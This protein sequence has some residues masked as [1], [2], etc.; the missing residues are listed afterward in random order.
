M[1]GDRLLILF[2]SALFATLLLPHAQAIPA[3]NLPAEI[4]PKPATE[5]TIQANSRVLGILPFADRQDFED[6]ER[7]FLAPLPNGGVVTG[8]DGSAVWDLGRYDFLG[9]D[10]SSASSTPSTVNPSLWRQSQLVYKSGLFKV[11]D[12]IYQVRGIDLSNITFIEGD[13]GLIVL[14]PLVSVEPAKAALELYYQHRP[15]KP[16]IAVL[17]SHSHVDHFGGVKGVTT[18]ADVRAGR[19]Q[20]IAPSGFLEEAVS[21]NVFAGNAMGRRA[22]Y[23]YGQL[24]P[25]GPQGVIGTGLGITTSKGSSSLIPPTRSITRTGEELTIDGLSF[26]FL[27]APDTEA[28]VEMHFYIKELRALCPAENATHTLHNVYTLRGAKIRDPRAWAKALDETIKLFGDKSDVLFAPH[29]WPVWGNERIVDLLEKQRDMYKY[30]NDQTLR[31]A[32]HGYKMNEIAER[33]QVPESLAK[34]WYLRGYYG[35]INHNVK[36]TYVKYLG[37]YDS[38]P[39]TLHPLPEVEASKRYVEFMG[40]ASSVLSKAQSYYKRG[41]Y[42]WVVQVVNHVVMAD[43]DDQA[44]RRLQADALEQ[45]GY[46]AESG[47]WRNEYLTAAQELRN[48]VKRMP[49]ASGFGPDTLASMSTELLF[50]Y[51][52]IRF[53]GVAAAD[54]TLSIGFDFTDTKEQVLASVKNGVLHHSVNADGGDVGVSLSRTTLNAILL[55]QISLDD[56]VS[57]G[58]V[59]ITGSRAL[60]QEFLS[61]L[62]DFDFWFD[63]VTPTRRD[64]PQSR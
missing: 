28:P 53:N 29:H 44:A 59:T 5:V 51:F 38:N 56:A 41:D 22:T 16:V 49:A 40:G 32:N 54:R 24:L 50:D 42:R 52:A 15:R 30:I 9:Q 20:I 31:L 6:A 11:A 34:E 64:A 48:G 18:D 13:T 4:G 2:T 35:S 1:R 46:Q 36:A 25:P 12:R 23:M 21:E 63:I 26:V 57:S 19:V 27:M 47:P 58:S 14:D 17:Y 60:F 37:W 8:G 45:L 43:P 3:S 61:M 39:A 7:G 62:D 55:R 10:A 33:F